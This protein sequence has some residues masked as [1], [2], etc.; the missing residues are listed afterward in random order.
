MREEYK[1][2]ECFFF[3]PHQDDELL[4]GGALLV[5]L[6][7]NPEWNVKVVYLTNGDA[8]AWEAVIRMNDAIRLLTRLGLKEQNIIFLGYG[9]RW[10]GEKH[11]YNAEQD[12]VC[13]S[14]AGYTRTYAL[15]HHK[16]Y[17]YLIKKI[18]HTYTRNNMKRDIKELLLKY[19]EM[20]VCV[21][22]DKHEDHRALS[23][24]F[25]ECMGEILKEKLDYR[26][27][28][29]KKF[30]YEGVWT[31]K[32]DYWKIPHRRTLK[33]NNQE[34]PFYLWK[35][36]ISL[37]VPHQCDTVLLRNNLLYK[38]SKIYRTQYVWM[39]APSFINSDIIFWR[40][41]TNNL[42]RYAEISASSGDVSFLSDFKLFDSANIKEMEYWSLDA[43]IWMPDI[44]DS[45]KRISILFSNPQ[46]YIEWL[47]I[48]ECSSEKSGITNVS[49]R[50]NH[51]DKTNYLIKER[52]KNVI[53]LQAID[54]LMIDIDI[55][56][57]YGEK[58][59]IS[60]IE[61]IE[62]KEIDTEIATAKYQEREYRKSC[63]RFILSFIC[64]FEKL[65]FNMHGFIMKKIWI[66]YYELNEYI[67]VDKSSYGQIILLRIILLLKKVWS[68]LTQ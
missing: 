32:K 50:I 59:G 47:N 13:E 60:E 64:C 66:P 63:S 10:K 28:V 22:Y 42:C 48:Y 40:R 68:F 5:E 39:S 53:R 7:N 23:L 17:S 14:I 36:R 4:I 56:K 67:N 11:I 55:T 8:R 19:P 2:K 26:P 37:R 38:L 3:V 21:D 6:I 18:H 30:A 35:E 45:V 27:V 49:I 51:G 31:G 1:M 29:F 61:L 52:T 65:L 44:K 33:G 43:G 41:E 15:K 46:K 24:L 16:E 62:R 9:N 57:F 12:D 34:H 54:V 58:I 20:C 25:D